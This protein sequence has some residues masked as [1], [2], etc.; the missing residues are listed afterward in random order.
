MKKNEEYVENRG[1][2]W[3]MFL[4][5]LAGAVALL[6]FIPEWVWISFPFVFTA[7]AGAMGRL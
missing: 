6:I 2:D 5:S 3:L 1:R 7:L 4:I